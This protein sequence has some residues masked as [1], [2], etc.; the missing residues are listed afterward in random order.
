MGIL[1]DKTPDCP[2]VN[3]SEDGLLEIEG[4]SITEDVFSFWQP[5]VDW[6]EQYVKTPA[7]FTKI[8][9]FL[10]YT[11][12]SS[13]KYLNEMMKH[14]D[15]CS[16]NG[17]NVEILWKYEEDDESILMLGQDLDAL[18]TVPFKFEEVEME[19][20]KTQKVKVKSKKTGNEAVITYR[21]WDAIV[22]N[23]HGDD[24][25]VLDEDVAL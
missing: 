14:L 17:N 16:T 20:I 2:Y 8:V 4:R 23:G 1:I 25:I 18:T 11:N 19:K 10:E 22:R 7:E 15:A 9:V 3:F 6:V 24:Y 12:S 21:Y 5:L 13:N